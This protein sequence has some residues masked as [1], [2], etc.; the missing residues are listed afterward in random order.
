MLIIDID[1]LI[2]D[3]DATPE[4][5]NGWHSGWTVDATNIMRVTI[6]YFDAVENEMFPCSAIGEL[7]ETVNDLID[8]DGSL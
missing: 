5:V 2:R 6:S 7:R 3:D 1:E 8:A 4:P